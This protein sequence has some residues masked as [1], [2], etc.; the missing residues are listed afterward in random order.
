MSGPEIIEKKSMN[1]VDVKEALEKIKKRDGELDIRG[2]K[3][4]EYACACSTLSKKEADEIYSKL[5]K[6]NIP[7]FKDMHINKIIDILPQSIPHIKVVLQGF[8]ITVSQES[9]KKILGV[10]SKYKSEK[11]PNKSAKEEAEPKEVVKEEAEP[12]EK[13]ES[14]KDAKEKTK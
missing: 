10:V 7:R 4:D 14:K 1:L 5:E 12:K 3:V 11:K 2:N 6:L 9:L 8:S 13:V